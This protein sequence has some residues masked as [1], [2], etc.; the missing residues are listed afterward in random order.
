MISTT[1]DCRSAAFDQAEVN[2]ALDG[3]SVTA[4]DAHGERLVV[5]VA[6]DDIIQPLNETIEVGWIDDR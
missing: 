5:V 4:E 1:C 3:R 6:R 2:L